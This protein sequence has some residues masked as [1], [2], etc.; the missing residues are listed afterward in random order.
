MILTACA[1]FYPALLRGVLRPGWHMSEREK[2]ARGRR[3]LPWAGLVVA[4][5]A[6]LVC[7]PG[8]GSGAA[9]AHGPCAGT[10]SAGMPAAKAPA[11]TGHA[12]PAPSASG[13]AARVAKGTRRQAREARS[14]E[15]VG[16]RRAAAVCPPTSVILYREQPAGQPPQRM[17][18]LAAQVLQHPG[19]RDSDER[20]PRR[21]RAVQGRTPRDRLSPRHLSH[22]LLRRHRRAQDHDGQPSV[23]AAADAAGVP[24]RHR[25]PV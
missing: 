14:G 15:P 19:L 25:R 11:G 20:Q 24:D 18:R 2:K 12:E 3:R 1:V 4:M 6:G 16:G 10:A 9:G 21:D 13:F 23:R 22:R 17:G 5:V 8:G 7:G